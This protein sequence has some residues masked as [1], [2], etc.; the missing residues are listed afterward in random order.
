MADPF[1]FSSTNSSAAPPIEEKSSAP[2]L[3]ILR[4]QLA[5]LSAS[6]KGHDKQLLS[7]SKGREAALRGQNRLRLV[8]YGYQTL[9]AT[10]QEAFSQI[11]KFLGV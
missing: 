6:V 1:P 7:L 3:K 4:Q 10:L 11:D 9:E 8:V 5:D 2:E